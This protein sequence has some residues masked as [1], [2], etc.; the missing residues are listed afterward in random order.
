MQSFDYQ[1]NGSCF[2]QNCPEH[3]RRDYR[4][5]DPKRE[6]L[7]ITYRGK[8]MVVTNVNS[9]L[10]AIEMFKV[11]AMLDDGDVDLYTT[12]VLEVGKNGVYADYTTKSYTDVLVSEVFHKARESKNLA[13][14]H[15][16]VV[17]MVEALA[18]SEVA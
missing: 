18:A 2:D 3:S 10:S 17:G 9:G 4:P 5:A 7:Y 16:G 1:D 11:V 13:Q 12:I 6:A 14:I 15:E 8:Y